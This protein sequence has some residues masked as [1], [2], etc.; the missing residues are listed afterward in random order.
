MAKH[1][2]CALH[3]GRWAHT[4]PKQASARALTAPQGFE[5]AALASASST[6][7]AALA[8]ALEGVH[9]QT[10]LPWWGSIVALTGA[11]RTL[12]LPLTAMQMRN[13]VNMSRAKPE[14][15]RLAERAKRSSMTGDP[16]DASRYRTELAQVWRRHN[17]HPIKGLAPALAQMPLFISFFYAVRGMSEV[18]SFRHGGAWFFEDLSSPATDPFFALPIIS[19]LLMLGAVELGGPEG[20]ALT[21]NMRWGMRGLSVAL[22]PLTASFPK[23]LFVYWISTNFISIVTTVLFQR[24]PL[25]RRLIGAP[26][27]Q[28]ISD[29]PPTAVASSS[30]SPDQLLQHRPKVQA[31]AQAGATAASATSSTADE[32]QIG[33]TVRGGGSSSGSG[34]SRRNQSKKA[35]GKKG[36]GKKRKK[37]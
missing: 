18:D 24:A 20:G 1:A 15:E 19:S 7:T 29:F 9:V 6:P 10:G 4:P 33:R 25:F 13:A 11:M 35:S 36:G 28:S 37:R 16:D 26:P 34:S 21:R 8:V 3:R 12:L 17:C 14:I 31:A 22:V 5:T 32:V 23:G 30:P 2:A 27:K